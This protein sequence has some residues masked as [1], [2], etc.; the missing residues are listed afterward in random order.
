[1]QPLR[2][3][4][5]F[6]TTHYFC[7]ANSLLARFFHFAPSLVT[8][9]KLAYD[10][11]IRQN[12]QQEGNSFNRLSISSKYAGGAPFCLA[13]GNC[14]D[15]GPTKTENLGSQWPWALNLRFPVKMFC[16]LCQYTVSLP[17]KEKEPE[18]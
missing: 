17:I 1:L 13:A 5:T 18:S 12:R 3:M 11:K 10:K 16:D 7:S 4:T 9:I 2:Q 14:R 8:W 15:E 6:A